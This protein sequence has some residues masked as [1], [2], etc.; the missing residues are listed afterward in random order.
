MQISPVEIAEIGAAFIV[1]K[2]IPIVLVVGVRMHF[3]RRNGEHP[4]I[5]PVPKHLTPV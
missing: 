3:V 4:A 2:V 1:L 5:E